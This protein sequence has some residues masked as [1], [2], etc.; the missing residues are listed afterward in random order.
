MRDV[1][2]PPARLERASSAHHRWLSPGDRCFFLHRYYGPLYSTI[3]DFKQRHGQSPQAQQAA[4]HRIASL[5]HRTAEPLLLGTDLV[6]PMPS[7]RAGAFPRLRRCIETALPAIPVIPLL[8]VRDGGYTTFHNRANRRP[9]PDYLT[10]R[11][12]LDSQIAH[13][14]GRRVLLVDDVLTTGAH[15]HAARALLERAGFDV[16]G[17]FFTAATRF[18]ISSPGA[19][20]PPSKPMPVQPGTSPRIMSLS[21]PPPPRE[22]AP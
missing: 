3:Q 12:Q 4:S 2:S 14:T 16:T 22:I 5:I 8:R 10:S 19:S 20:S 21:P 9:G 1:I 13:A 11:L 17:L 6:I 15:W 18:G 7:S